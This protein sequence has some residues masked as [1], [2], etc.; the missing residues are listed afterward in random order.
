MMPGCWTEG[1]GNIYIV[2]IPLECDS[3]RAIIC[4]ITK[5][6]MGLPDLAVDLVLESP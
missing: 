4:G 3:W 5:N 2:A 6:G 1:I